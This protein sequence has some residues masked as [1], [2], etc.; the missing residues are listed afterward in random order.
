M[1]KSISEIVN[2]K[3]VN[4]TCIDTQIDSLTAINMHI[5]YNNN[6]NKLKL[7]VYFFANVS[8]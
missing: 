4:H 1:G 3:N 7:C 6:N 8:Q 2:V 5:R